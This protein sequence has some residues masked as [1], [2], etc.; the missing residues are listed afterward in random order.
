MWKR[1]S[2]QLLRWS[3][4]VICWQLTASPLFASGQEPTELPSFPVTATHFAFSNLELPITAEVIGREQIE[5]FA[6]ISLPEVLAQFSGL[7][8]RTG[9]GS[10]ADG[11]V[12][13]RG[14]GETAGRRVLVLVN[15]RRVNRPDLGGINWLQ[16][17]TAHIG[18]VEVL[19]GGQGVI[20]GDQAIGGVINITTRQHSLPGGEISALTGSYG[21]AQAQVYSH[22]PV[23]ERNQIQVVANWMEQEGY[24]ENSAFKGASAS[25]DWSRTLA[26]GWAWNQHLQFVDTESELPGPLYSRDFPQNPRRST[27]SGQ[28]S[29]E[30]HWILDSR[31]SHPDILHGSIDLPL[32]LQEQKLQWNL[33]GAWG[34][35]RLHTVQFRPRKSWESE[36]FRLTGGIDGIHDSFDFTGWRTSERLTS[37]TEA[38]LIRRALS[39][40]IHAH[41]ELSPAW[42][43]TSGLRL[44][45]WNVRARSDFRPYNQ[46]E[47]PMSRQYDERISETGTAAT[48]GLVWQP[49]TSF[50]IWTRYDRLFRFPVTDEL[51]SYQGYALAEPFNRALSP[52]TG[53]SV[54]L[55]FGYQTASWFYLQLVTFGQR[56]NNE[57]QYDP[58]AF[59]NTNLEGSDRI[60]FEVSAEFRWSTFELALSGTALDA[61]IRDGP[62]KGKTPALIP[63]KIGSIRAS[64]TPVPWG[65]VSASLRYTSRQYEGNYLA[66]EE[67]GL[68]NPNP[69]VPSSTVTDLSALWRI[70]EK[71]SLRAVLE[72]AFDTQYATT[73]FQSGWYPAPGRSWRL[74][75]NARF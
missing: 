68:S 51:A 50:R 73:K 74:Q 1:T 5:A 29:D 33:P 27:M 57:I 22:F 65:T 56:L 18:K 67:A 53:H 9:T 36:H 4:F 39:T 23:G 48:T 41:W 8:V 28:N 19:K 3:Q 43:F 12:D 34:S 58:I 30:R 54:E 55:G 40:Y 32:N 7:H 46:P 14:Q 16:I 42:R 2:S 49:S 62:S 11:T 45:N 10:P 70:T 26:S 75:L 20:Y 71:W 35:N 63:E 15:G 31:L 52:E 13:I 44:E 69:F 38:K 6:A 37:L 25:L 72:N 64:W 21:L 60:G 59:L 61:E 24:R 66:L 17:P 47:A